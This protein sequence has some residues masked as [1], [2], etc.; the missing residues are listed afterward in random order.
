MRRRLLNFGAAVS[1]GLCAA[2]AAGW[3][4]GAMRPT[5]WAV[6]SIPQ[7]TSFVSLES[8]HLILSEQA[9]APTLLPR[10]YG[11]DTSRSL[12]FA[13][14]HP[15]EPH[16]WGQTL[17]R[18]AGLARPTAGWFRVISTPTGGFKFVRA[19]GTPFV[20]VATFYRALE[21]PWWSLVLAFAVWP[22]AWALARH[23]S[24]ARRARGLCPHCGYDLR[25][26]PGRCPE[27]GTSASAKAAA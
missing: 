25:A 10:P 4:V 20:Q 12:R 2:A 6:R 18:D 21:V 15:D 8:Q 5:A 26:S 13:L 19:D 27:C 1:L 22:A 3:A 9:M 14:T 16:G 24:R 23:R 11:I 7:R 17:D